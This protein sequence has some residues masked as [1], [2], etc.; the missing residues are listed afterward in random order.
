MKTLATFA[1]LLCALIAGAVLATSLPAQ[2]VQP[3]YVLKT[4]SQESTPKYVI[5]KGFSQSGIAVE[6][7]RAVEK[8]DPGLKF[9]GL[10]HYRPFARIQ[11]ELEQGRLD[12]FFGIAKTARQENRFI[13]LDPPLYMM[14]DAFYVR[15][16]DAVAINSLDDIRKTGGGVLAW[17]GTIQ[18]D[19]VQQQGLKLAGTAKSIELG[20][21]M[22]LGGRGRF[23]YGNELSTTAKIREMK[24]E[25]KIRQVYLHHISGRYVAVSRSMD[26]GAKRR[27]SAAL[28]ALKQQGELNRIFLKYCVEVLPRRRC[29]QYDLD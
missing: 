12:V 7:M 17:E 3:A 9:T 28:A 2:G 5:R 6:V 21:K 18:H 1:V 22:L 16:D 29:E 24:L 27:L 13:F 14:G 23:W 25:G 20:L 15:A 10:E 4:A 11:A 26:E 8:Q 19:Y